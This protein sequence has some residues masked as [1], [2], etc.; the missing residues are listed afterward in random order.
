MLGILIMFLRKIPEV[1]EAKGQ[2][3]FNGFKNSNTEEITD[4]SIRFLEK[5]GMRLKEATKRLLG[6]VWQFMLEAKDL[7]EG[8]ILASNFSKIVAGSSK[9][10]INIAAFNQIKK[11]ERQIEQGDLEGAEETYFEIL[12][13]HPH[14]YPAYEGLIR[15]YTKQKKNEELQEILEYL[16]QHHPGNHSYHAQLG[17]LHL[18]NRRF[19]EAAEEYEKSIDLNTLIPARFA[20][21]GLAY[22]GMGNSL[23]ACEYYRKAMDLEPSNMQYL[24]LL[25]DCLVRA[26][27]KQ[28][29]IDTLKK[30][31]EMDPGNAVIQERLLKLE[32]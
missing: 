21:A 16:I 13:K 2:L 3:K 11:A 26:D 6:K 31:L 15:I 29:A 27:K 25:V 7:K 22:Q 20:N 23:K 1:A 8:R 32:S 4:E 9:R 14:E 18:S 19:A 5:L 12:K 10:V 17:K 28:D 24:S 30:A